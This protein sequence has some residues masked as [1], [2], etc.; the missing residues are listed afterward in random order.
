VKQKWDKEGKNLRIYVLKTYIRIVFW[1]HVLLL[2]YGMHAS[3][4]QIIRITG[5][6]HHNNILSRFSM[7]CIVCSTK[8]QSDS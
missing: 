5:V 1:Q 4:L 2:Y 3:Q 6:K 8:V 7:L